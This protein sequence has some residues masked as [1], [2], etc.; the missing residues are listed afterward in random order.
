MLVR[1]LALVVVMLAAVPGTKPAQHALLAQEGTLVDRIAAVVGD[2]VIVLSQINERL[3]QLQ[4]QGVE[5]PSPGSDARRQLQRDV[6]DQMIGEMLIV[7]AALRDT[8]IVIDEAEVENAVSADLQQRMQQFGGQTAFQEALAEEGWTLTSYRDFLRV[9]ARQQR[10][11][12]LFMQ[13]QTRDLASIVVEE[14]E[15]REFFEEQKDVLGQRPPSVTFAQVIIEPTPSDSAVDAARAEAQRIRELA[16]EGE[17]FGELARRFSQDPG[18]KDNGGEL[19]WFRRGEMV[20]AFEDAA[21]RL[22]VNEISEPVKTPFGFHVIRLDRRRSGEIRASHILIPVQASSEDQERAR[23]DALSVKARLEAGEPLQPLRE[24]FGDLEAPDTLSVPFDQLQQLP[25]GF[26]EPLLQA[27]GGDVL[28]PIEY[29]VQERSNFGVLKVIR[30][31]EGG[32]YTL[33]DRELRS[34][35]VQNLQQQKLVA[36]IL[37]ELRSEFYVQ[38]RM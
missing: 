24:A 15:I 22:A 19:G 10:L 33:E 11:Y 37:E 30:V 35:I 6:L 2:S 14:E 25:P 28:G 7:Q 4:Y 29:Q 8:T 32:E 26:A 16:L 38:I 3:L 34:R 17:D 1:S 12:G 36:R 5:V 31:R 20:P 23:D 21:F 9:Q 13:G 27:E 18:S